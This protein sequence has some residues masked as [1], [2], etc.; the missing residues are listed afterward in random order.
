MPSVAASRKR[1]SS[2][3]EFKLLSRWNKSL[4]NPWLVPPKRL[5]PLS[6]SQLL[7]RMLRFQFPSPYLSPVQSPVQSPSPVQFQFQCTPPAPHV[8]LLPPPS[9]QLSFVSPLPLFPFP[10]VNLLSRPSLSEN[11]QSLTWTAFSLSILWVLPLPAL[12][13]R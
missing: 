12:L 6:P 13:L 5:Y 10:R 1:L 11:C 4:H 7:E 2:R 8:S 3:K 9:L